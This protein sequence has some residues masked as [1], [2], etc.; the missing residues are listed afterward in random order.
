[1]ASDLGTHASPRPYARMVPR[2]IHPPTAVAH[3]GLGC[4][5]NVH[6]QPVDG[7]SERVGNQQA[8]RMAARA[9]P[10]CVAAPFIFLPF[11]PRDFNAVFITYLGILLG[12]GL[13]VLAALS[14]PRWSAPRWVAWALGASL[15]SAVWFSL[16]SLWAG[17]PRF[18]LY[19]PRAAAVWVLL[20]VWLVAGTMV[21][22]S[23]TLRETMIAVA[24]GGSFVAVAAI[25][26]AMTTGA[27]RT[28]GYAAGFLENSTSSGAMIAVGMVACVA[29]L[30]ISRS[31]LQRSAYGVAL[32]VSTVALVMSSSRAAWLGLAAML[33]LAA[34]I[35][36]LSVRRSRW[37]LLAAVPTALGL[38]LTSFEVAAATGSLG[39]GA[40]RALARIGTDR[41]AIWRS[42]WAQFTTAPVIGEGIGQFSATIQSGLSSIPTATYDT[43]NILI[44]AALGGGLIGLVLVLATVFSLTNAGATVALSSGKTRAT[45][46][47]ASLPVFLLTVGL[48]AWVDS[49]ALLTIAA[50]FGAF[51]GSYLS[52]PTA[53]KEQSL[54]PPGVLRG[55][56]VFIAAGAVLISVVNFGPVSMLYEY[57][58][59][60]PTKT[61]P[62][63]DEALALYD[64]LPEGRV[65]IYLL[66]VLKYHI[67]TGSAD[68]QAKAPA[69]LR[70]VEPD[71]EVD[72]TVATRG[73]ALAQSL[74]NPADPK[75]FPLVEELALAGTHADPASGIWYA[76]LAY[77]AE[78]RGM[79]ETAVRYAREALTFPQDEATRARLEAIAGS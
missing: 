66:G 61:A 35:T 29:G 79:S 23:R 12:G 51:L 13:C 20:A 39:T 77:D 22:D 34:C 7:G 63:L 28:Q 50:L 15:L 47:L 70:L 19:S 75:G 43:H 2:A 59:S 45:A 38:L 56:A 42:A 11:L 14:G 18:A 54:F 44:G 17:N 46:L 5:T 3:G 65:A 48:F 69:V 41:D 16:S 62:T 31:V 71:A 27:Q 9:Y 74:G 4:A 10:Y 73:V 37:W 55:A 57:G 8:A 26:E 6:Y 21:A 58:R 33:V 49:A 24:A 76:L 1:M 25:T 30:L 72:V 78:R 53:R 60:G 40:L 68:A 32:L 67:A 36:L 52:G 64:R